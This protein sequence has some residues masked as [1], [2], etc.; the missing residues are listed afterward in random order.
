MRPSR[1]EWAAIAGFVEIEEQ[2]PVAWPLASLVLLVLFLEF[3]TRLALW[4]V[5]PAPRNHL[6]YRLSRP[7]P[8][9]DAD[10]YSREF[11][12]DAT[13]APRG[14]KKPRGTNH[15]VATDHESAYVSY[16]DGK[17]RTLFQPADAAHVVKLFGGSTMV[18]GE[19]PD[20]FTIAS[21]LQA[22]LNGSFPGRFRVENL[23]ASSVV[24]HQELDRLKYS[25]VE[26]ADVVVFY[27]GVNDIIQ[28]IYRADAPGTMIQY[29][30]TLKEQFSV[31]QNIVF[32]FHAH[33]R[34]HSA[35]VRTFMD[36]FGTALPRHISQPER[37]QSLGDTLE[38]RYLAAIIEA[39][40]WTKERRARFHHFVQP[41][42]FSHRELSD[43]EA[44][45]AEL[46]GIVRPGFGSRS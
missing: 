37:M 27:D 40:S 9:R 12:L 33:W 25:T 41:N 16:R 35:F 31:A 21:Q 20:E 46:S 43:Y 3:G 2:E 11:V 8:Y 17:R 29:N 22:Q 45:L 6:E 23:G 18:G 44:E 36:P 10:Y 15:L 42:L 19:V 32:W 13:K 5:E 34:K 1:D 39:H 26:S 24:I 4:L 38:S 30:R 7:A 28:S 14:W